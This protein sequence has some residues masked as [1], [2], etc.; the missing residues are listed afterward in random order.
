[1]ENQLKIT[2]TAYPDG[3]VVMYLHGMM[4]PAIK[5][6]GSIMK[7]AVYNSIVNE[8]TQVPSFMLKK[9]LSKAG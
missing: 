8:N 9:H 3:S 5:N 2:N 4:P 1:M 7:Q 6:M